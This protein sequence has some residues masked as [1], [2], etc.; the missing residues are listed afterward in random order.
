MGARGAVGYLAAAFEFEPPPERI[1]LP[2]GTGTTA[3]GLLAGFALRGAATEVVA[4]DVVGSRFAR[5]AAL[6]RRAAAAV[7]RLRRYD[8]AVPPLSPGAVRLRVVPSGAPYG[9]PTEEALA[10]LEAA[11]PLPL[12]A[13]YSAPTLA[14]LLRERAAGAVFLLTSPA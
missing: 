7:R 4:V 5:P 11:R 2:L 13:T 8:P 14:V 3:V 6:W 9:E 1:Y 12:E 10:A